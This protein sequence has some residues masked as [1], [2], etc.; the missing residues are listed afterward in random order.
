MTKYILNHSEWQEHWNEQ[1][2][3]ITRS[4]QYF[5]QDEKEARRIAAAL[6]ILFHQ[7]KNQ[8]QF[9]ATYHQYCF[10]PVLDCIPRQT[11]Y[12]HGNYCP[13]K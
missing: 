7:T 4:C 5:K 6:H 12:H 13:W 11:Y 1:L 10:I 3:F 9:I 2:A 8:N